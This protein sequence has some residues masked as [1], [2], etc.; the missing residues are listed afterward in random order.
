M[1]QTHLYGKKQTMEK[2]KRGKMDVVPRLKGYGDGD[3]WW[4]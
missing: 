3:V 4:Q 1:C 2:D